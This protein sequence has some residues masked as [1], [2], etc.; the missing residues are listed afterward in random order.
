MTKTL[1]LSGFL[2]PG[3]V[4]EFLQDNEAHLAWVL[5]EAQGRLRLLTRTKREVKLPAARLLPWSGPEFAP[6]ATREEIGHKLDDIEARRRGIMAGVNA[7]ELWEMAQGELTQAPAEWFA[8][9]LWTE[10]GVDEIAALGRALLAAKAHFKFQPPDFEIHPADKVEARLAREQED[11]DRE[12]VASAGHAVFSALW[13]R[14]K[15]G[16]PP[17]S[18]H[19]VLREA[20]GMDPEVE[21]RLRAMLLAQVAKKTSGGPNGSGNGE[22]DAL[23][24]LWE[25]LKKPLPI[26]GEAPHLALQLA[27]A[28]GVLPPHHNHLLDEVGYAWGDGWSRDFA[29]EIAAQKERFATLAAGAQVD[30][31]PYVSIDAATTRDIDDAFFVAPATLPDG[32]AGYSCSVTLARPGVTWDFGSPLDREVFSRSTSLYLPEGSGHM[33]PEELGTG[34]YSL[35]ADG[36]KPALVA[37]FLLNE[38]AEIVEARPRLAW[39]KIARNIAYPDAQA[40]IDSGSDAHICLGMKIAREL[41]QRRL[42]RGAVVID[43]P[44]PQVVLTGEPQNISVDIS[45]RETSP[46]AELL[47][48][49][50][51]ILANSGM[52]LWARERGVPLLCRTQDIA[53]PKEATGVFNDAVDIYRVVKLL[54]PPALECQPRKHAALACE[55]YATLTSPIRRYVDFL[56]MAQV[57]SYLETGAPRLD[58]AGLEAIIPHLSARTQEVGQ[59]QRF[60][61]RYWKL[62]YLSQHKREPFPAVVVE[63]AGPYPTLSL[64]ELQITTRVPRS[65]LGDRVQPGMRFDLFFGRIDALTNELKVVEAR[66]AE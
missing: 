29:G 19:V 35:T 17:L 13:A 23:A 11:K 63:D 8:Q 1:K 12:A 50:F 47:V 27:Q 16:Q 24:K 38:R 60:R 44:E 61:P 31:T 65:M 43:K 66:E 42:E 22:Y 32:N 15:S 28:W 56:N 49:E 3:A 62:V 33:M 5:E 53:L 57:Q 39:V 30:P 25:N 52:A 34:L 14:I 2:R 58:R 54:A 6:G 55:A 10:P 46:D 40:A 21:A 37:E 7:M 41:F 64:P 20:E 4:V 36:P 59:V 48:S 9:L 51:M 26:K 45:L 18:P